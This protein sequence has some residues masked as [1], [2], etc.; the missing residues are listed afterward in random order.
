MCYRILLQWS[1][2]SIPILFLFFYESIETNRSDANYRCPNKES[3]RSINPNEK[4]RFTF[5]ISAAR[6]SHKRVKSLAISTPAFHILFHHAH[7]DK[8]I[9]FRAMLC[10]NSIKELLIF[11]M[12]RRT[13]RSAVRTDDEI[14]KLNVCFIHCRRHSIQINK[15]ETQTFESPLLSLRSVNANFSRVSRWKIASTAEQ[16]LVILSRNC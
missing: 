7:V 9:H 3:R 4:G 10:E 2:P 11:S 12:R 15:R 16:K 8:L 6:I 1:W 14:G 5:K 13:F